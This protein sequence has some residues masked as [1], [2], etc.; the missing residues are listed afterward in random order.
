MLFQ[1]YGFVSFAFSEWTKILPG[2]CF[3]G[4]HVLERKNGRHVAIKGL[5]Q[6]QKDKQ[7]LVLRCIF[8]GEGT[9]EKHKPSVFMTK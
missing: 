7:E 2:A 9:K 3:V 8:F 6:V 1:N 5:D 4:K